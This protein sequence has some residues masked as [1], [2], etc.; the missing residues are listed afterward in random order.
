MSFNNTRTKNKSEINQSKRKFTVPEC[1][2]RMGSK[3]LYL[4]PYLEGKLRELYPVTMNPDLMDMF[5]ISSSTLHRFARALGLKKDMEVI[6]KL[7]V[8]QIMKTCRKNG[9]YRSLKGKAPSEACKEASRRLRQSGFHPLT[10]VREK[11][12]ERYGR[13]MKRRSRN[14][15]KLLAQ[16]ARR[17]DMGFMPLT[18][19][20]ANY[21]NGQKYSKAETFTRCWARKKGY[22]PGNPDPELGER[23]TIF[24]DGNTERGK[25]FERNAVSRGFQFKMKPVRRACAN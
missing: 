15:K 20:P 16:E 10:S 23:Y 12:P 11:D 4:T 22:F 14:R 24:F 1:E 6:K 13:L 3:K 19:I 8:R 25:V 2:G 21:Y 18:G 9:Y 5:G 17:Y 7:H